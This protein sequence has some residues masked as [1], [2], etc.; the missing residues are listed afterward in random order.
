MQNFLDKFN[1]PA[2]STA[3]TSNM[4]MHHQISISIDVYDSKVTDDERDLANEMEKS[5]SVDEPTE[6]NNNNMFGPSVMRKSSSTR[7]FSLLEN[8]PSISTQ[9][10]VTVPPILTGVA[11]GTPQSKN[12]SPNSVN[13]ARSGSKRGIASAEMISN[14]EVINGDGSGRSS[15]NSST[16][17]KKA[18]TSPGGSKGLIQMTMDQM[19]P[20]INS[21]RSTHSAKDEARDS[22]VSMSAFAPV[23][24]SSSTGISD[25]TWQCSACTF[26]NKSA[27]AAITM[28]DNPLAQPKEEETCAVCS[29]PRTLPAGGGVTEVIN[30]LD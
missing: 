21:A 7:M 9:G 20:P 23:L 8:L 27:A 19:L 22:F 3:A 11:S 4:N 6:T 16:S 17:A 25:W 15:N 30:L 26:V 24:S 13:S 28:R 2:A 18:K 14:E 29:I 12:G 10:V 5:M 1:V